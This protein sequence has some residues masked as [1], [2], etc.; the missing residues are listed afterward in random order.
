MYEYLWVTLGIV[1]SVQ[2]TWQNCIGVHLYSHTCYIV[3]HDYQLNSRQI[4]GVFWLM[5]LCVCVCVNIRKFMDAIISLL[6]EVRC[7]SCEIEGFGH[8]Y[9]QNLSMRDENFTQVVS[10]SLDAEAFFLFYFCLVTWIW[11]WNIPFV[12][13]IILPCPIP[14]FVMNLSRVIDGMLQSKY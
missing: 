3:Y 12:R 14:D 10:S 2:Q 6:S 9:D 7:E 4:F 11:L 5:C 8:F 1:C 13:V